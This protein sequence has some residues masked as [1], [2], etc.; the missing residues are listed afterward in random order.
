MFPLMAD[1]LSKM[2]RTLILVAEVDTIR[3]D[4]LLYHKRLKDAGVDVK[5]TIYRS[6][7][8]AYFNSIFGRWFQPHAYFPTL[9][10][11]KDF[12]QT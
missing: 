8:H 2:P 5:L 9:E 1:D 10:A 3:D 6:A 12:T 11:M 4:G 7:V